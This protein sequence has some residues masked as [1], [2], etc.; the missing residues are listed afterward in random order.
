MLASHTR[1]GLSLTY[2]DTLARIESAVSLDRTQ[3]DRLSDLFASREAEERHLRRQMLTTYTPFQQRQ[4]HLIWQEQKGR[5]LTRKERLDL[6]ARLNITPSQQA[7]LQA[8]EAKIQAHR[9]ATMA[10]VADLLSA[11]QR[12]LLVGVAGNFEG[13]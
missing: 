8:Y 13:L 2:A 11:Q 12:P 10:K 3:T 7:Q 5:P 1:Q 4:A 6:R 9:E